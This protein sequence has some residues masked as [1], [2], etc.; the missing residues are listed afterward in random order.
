MS[1]EVI[2]VLVVVIGFGA[3]LYSRKKAADA[4]KKK[5]TRDNSKIYN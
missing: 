4:K 5:Q 2:L 3:F 1:L